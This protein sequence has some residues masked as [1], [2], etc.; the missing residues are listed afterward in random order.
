MIR[1]LLELLGIILIVLVSF[2][3]GAVGT[4]AALIKIIM[5]VPTDYLINI[6]IDYKNSGI[7]DISETSRFFRIKLD[8]L[9]E[10]IEQENQ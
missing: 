2:L 4:V 7:T 1:I 6:L 10:I 3:A 5:E 9:K 8:E